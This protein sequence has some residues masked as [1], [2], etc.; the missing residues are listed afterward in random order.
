MASSE[1]L[2]MRDMG[3]RAPHCEMIG[4]SVVDGWMNS[5]GKE[6]QLE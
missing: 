6:D 2:R 4:A 5:V 1:M 3:F